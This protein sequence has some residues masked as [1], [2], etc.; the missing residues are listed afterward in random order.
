MEGFECLLR[1]G[2]GVLSQIRKDQPVGVSLQLQ[3]L[4]K[5][6]TQFFIIQICIIVVPEQLC[7]FQIVGKEVDAGGE[8]AA[9]LRAAN[10]S[11]CFQIQTV[12]LIFVIFMCA[13]RPDGIQSCR[14]GHIPLLPGLVGC[15]H[16]VFRK[17]PAEED[18]TLFYGDF[19]G[20]FLTLGKNLIV[21]D[22]GCAYGN[23]LDGILYFVFVRIPKGYR[24]PEIC[25]PVADRFY[26]FIP[27]FLDTVFDLLLC[28]LPCFVK[29]IGNFILDMICQLF[30][31]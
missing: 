21:R 23:I 19:F 17:T 13:F 28:I 16:C 9:A 27:F 29:S 11:F 3:I 1:E 5:G 7:G 31:V 12:Q 14:L 4:R 6:F 20:D 8:Y 30:G 18:I 10:L 26:D 15:L 2:G 24:I 22:I 25:K